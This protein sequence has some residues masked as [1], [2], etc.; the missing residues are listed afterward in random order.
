MET[1]ACVSFVLMTV[2]IIMTTVVVATH[3]KPRVKKLSL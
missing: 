3:D 2:I 1:T